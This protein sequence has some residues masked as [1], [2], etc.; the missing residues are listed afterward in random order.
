MEGDINKLIMLCWDGSK[1]KE[2]ERKQ[3]RKCL[4]FSKG[5]WIFITLLNQFRIK[6]VH[7]IASEQAFNS[8]SELLR[9]VLDEI[10]SA[11]DTYVAVNCLLL[12][13]TFYYNPA[14]IGGNNQKRFLY[15]LIADHKIWQDNDFW[16]RAITCKCQITNLD[17]QSK[18]RK[19]SV[20]IRSKSRSP[21]SLILAYNRRV[22]THYLLRRKQLGLMRSCLQSSQVSSKRC[23]LTTLIRA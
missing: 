23:S 6:N 2:D 7:S 22:G 18:S 15:E 21:T 11:S 4:R 13:S 10:N 8:I 20:S 5:Q 19:T 17:A 3:F 12:S 1:L 9:I 14:T 16:E